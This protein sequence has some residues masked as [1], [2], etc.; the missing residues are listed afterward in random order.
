MVD[1]NHSAGHFNVDPLLIGKG[2]RPFLGVIAF[3]ESVIKP[4]IS[5]AVQNDL[6]LSSEF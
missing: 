3:R 4:V 6:T 1:V 2:I 5:L